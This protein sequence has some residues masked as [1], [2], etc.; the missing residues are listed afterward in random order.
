MSGTIGIVA[1]DLGRYTMFTK[2]LIHIRA[3]VNTQIE[4]GVG[5][6][7]ANNR[8]GLVRQSLDRGSEWMFFLDDDHAFPPDHLIRLLSHEQPIVAS[9]YASRASP[10]NPIAYDFVSEAEGWTAVELKG[11]GKDELVAV[12]GAGTGGMLVRSEVFHAMPYPWFEKTKIGS[13]DLEFCRKA[14]ELGF[15][16]LLDLGAPMGHMTTASIWPSF[17]DGDWTSG[18]TMADGSSI[19]L[20]EEGRS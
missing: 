1:S 20:N 7:F 15:P 10:F 16:V 2:C 14:K 5:T 3:P 6:D 19:F 11:R 4:W 9:L 13:E 18:I 17:V 8:N 12:D